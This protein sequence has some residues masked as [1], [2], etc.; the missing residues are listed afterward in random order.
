MTKNEINPIEMSERRYLNDVI[1][2]SNE[3][4]KKGIKFI[5]LTGPTSSGK[6]TTADII[7]NKLSESGKNVIRISLDDFFKE[8]PIGTKTSDTDLDSPDTMDNQLFADFMKLLVAGKS[9]Q[10]PI[11][12]FALSIRQGYT[13]IEPKENDIFL[14]EG[15][16]CFYPEISAS[17]PKD[18]SL[19][20]FVS[21]AEGIKI[22]NTAFEPDEIRFLRRSIRDFYYRGASFAFTARAWKNVRKNEIHN[23]EPYVKQ[24]DMRISSLMLYE[25]NMMKDV[26]LGLVTEKDC[27][28]NK[29][30]DTMSKKLKEIPSMSLAFLPE[31]SLLNEFLGKAKEK[32]YENKNN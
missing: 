32:K 19:S 4:I 5:T 16:Q 20:I 8:I 3:V 13:T 22:N 11:F 24:A 2:V 18:K 31:H 17:I 15:I 7:K 12:D 21:V 25:V 30:I 26:F 28:D 10:I 27:K 14:L 6:T 1:N 9:C 29:I 23:I